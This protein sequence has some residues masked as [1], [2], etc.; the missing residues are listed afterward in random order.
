M[1][2]KINADWVALAAEACADA[3]IKWRT[4]EPIRTMAQQFED[5]TQ[6]HNNTVLRVDDHLILKLYGPTQKH[7]YHVEQAVLQT[8]ANHA[9]FAAPRLVATA[10]LPNTFPYTF[11]TVIDGEAPDRDWT[12]YS[13]TERLSL[14]AELGTITRE[15]HQLPL[16]LL[17]R[18][19]AK[20]GGAKAEITR[21][22]SD[23]LAEIEA[24]SLFTP[25]QREQMRRFVLEK[26]HQF[27]D[28]P[29][30]LTHAD[31]SHAHLFVSRQMGVPFVTG[32]IDW[33][34]ALI[35]P[36][37]WDIAAHWCWSFTFD[38]PMMHACLAAYYPDG[39]PSRLA[40]RSLATFFY[41]YSMQLLWP[42]LFNHPFK[43]D[44][45]IREATMRLFPPEVFGPPD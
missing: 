40:R 41:T 7:A 45:P 27:F 22:Q 32:Y 24:A 6:Y 38:R 29:P 30:V 17:L 34:E 35:G 36:A 12:G 13:Q 2:E 39:L 1:K 8:L 10:E 43:T 33:G 31:L 28:E 21:Q 20:Q 16:E 25:W 19:E 3:G 4:I 26:G 5:S 37:T 44:D 23:R 42:F 15:L 9:Q 11:M 18:L 14:A